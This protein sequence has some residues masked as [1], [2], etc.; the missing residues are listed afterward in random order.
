MNKDGLLLLDRI[1][2]FETDGDH[3][4]TKITTKQKL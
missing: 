1:I 2:L 4:K 3:Y